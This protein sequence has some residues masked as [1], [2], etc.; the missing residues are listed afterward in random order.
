[1]NYEELLN[2]LEIEEAAQFEYFETMADL[3]E[4]E[5]Y[6]DSEAVYKLF[7]GA[8]KEV[9]SQLIDEYFED[10]LEGLPED[11][12]EIYSLLHQV[13]LC[14]MGMITNL[15]EDSDLTRFND[16]FCRFMNWY[17]HES[18]VEL[19]PKDGGQPIYHNLRDAITSARLEKLG[20]EKYAFNFEP[21]MTYQPDSYTI[22]FAELAAIGEEGEL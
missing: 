9:S 22:S 8:D 3:L 11:A 7:E 10:I 20:G 21:A 18:E 4:N 2:Y 1:M 16:E 12:G 14:L 19:T 6:I 13:K 15:E 5:E 17:S